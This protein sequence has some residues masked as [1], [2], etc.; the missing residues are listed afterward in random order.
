M[1]TCVNEDLELAEA[2]VAETRKHGGLAPVDLD[3]FWADQAIAARDPFGKD[4][5]QVAFGAILTNE[6]VFDELGI[7]EDMWK[8]GN[9]EAWALSLN[10][11]YNDKA[12][13]IVGRRLLNET[14][15]DPTRRYPGTKGLADIFEAKNIWHNGSWW[16]QPS[17]KGETELE[18][19]LDRV[20][21][22]VENL[23]T[24]REFILPE[25]W[26]QEKARLM[27]LG[28]TPPGYHWQRGPVTFA[29]SI[30]GAEDFL[31]L[32]LDNPD[33]AARLRDAILH[34]M[35][36]IGTVL[37]TEAGHTPDTAPQGFGFAD[38]NC[39]L[40]SPDMY[41]FWAYPILKGVFDAKAAKPGAWRYQHSDSAMGHLLPILGRLNMTGVNF[42]PTVRAA[43]IR[44]HLPR[45]VIEGTMAPFTYSR[46]EEVNIVLEFL[47]DVRETRETRGLRFTTAGS[48][49]N[50]TRLT[51]MRLAMAAVQRYGRFA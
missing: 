30:Y 15:S 10:K 43:E 33:L 41:D 45:A 51:S 37:D 12:E 29:T 27:A 13:R 28:V 1:T 26:A 40:M 4:I 42:G 16:L 21:R 44:A 38:D 19:L 6:C 14:P 34:A 50:G 49:N 24:L 11:A 9:D 2:L 7:P 5:P 23:Q 3:R 17:A 18:A 20:E 25:N 47:R 8:Y 22:R 31:L 39:C 48:I 46:N 36:G 32:V 35:L